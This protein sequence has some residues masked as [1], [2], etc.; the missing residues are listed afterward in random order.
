MRRP[1]SALV[2][3]LAVSIALIAPV[4][5]GNAAFSASPP[6]TSPAEAWRYADLADL[7]LETPIVVTARIV[8]AIPVKDS[9]TTPSA[10]F[11]NRYYL[12]ADV[13]A[14]IRGTG[15]ISPRVAWIADVPLDNRGKVPRLKKTQ[16]IL[17]ALPVADRPGELR[18]AARDAMVPWSAALE[19]RVRAVVASGLAPDAPARITR[20]TSAFHSPGNLPGEGETQVFLSTVRGQSVSINVL[21]RPGLDP[22]WAVALGE[23]IDEAGR[24][25]ARDTIGWYRLAC[26][27][28]NNLP[29][30]AVGELSASDAE[31]ARADYKFVMQSLG[32]CPRLR[33]QR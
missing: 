5:G 23:F 9:G 18:L 30:S 27:L 4:F 26:F 19:T 31:A 15:G 8:E 1:P 21:R 14:L 7:F 29:A 10:G 25:P 24:P 28:P 17:A 16:V 2:L 6:P 12:V 3:K 20:I 22:Q 33:A 11:A 13:T 32:P